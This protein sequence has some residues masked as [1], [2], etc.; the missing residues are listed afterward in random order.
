MA[1]AKKCD[2]CG[3]F[4]Q[5]VEQNVVEQLAYNI[6]FLARPK[7]DT[8]MMLIEQCV[9]LCPECSRSLKNWLS[10]KKCDTEEPGED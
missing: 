7:N 10:M 9:D 5:A 4:Y 3:E 8:T 1:N 6:G 2:R